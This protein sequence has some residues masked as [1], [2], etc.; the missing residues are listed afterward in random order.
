MAV[1]AE[2]RE[3]SRL[4]IESKTAPLLKAAE[5]GNDVEFIK[6]IERFG[7]DVNA[8]DEE[9]YYTPLMIAAANSRLKVVK[10]LL[11]LEKDKFVLKQVDAIGWNALIWACWGV[12]A[13]RGWT[14]ES[15]DVI[16]S[17]CDAYREKPDYKD[18]PEDLF[19]FHKTHAGYTPLMMFV[20]NAGKKIAP[21]DSGS[22]ETRTPLT[23]I[24]ETLGLLLPSEKD[25]ERPLAAKLVYLERNQFGESAIQLCRG[26]YGK[27]LKQKLI[28]E[29]KEPPE[30]TGEAAQQEQEKPEEATG[31][32][33]AWCTMRA[34]KGP[35]S[36]T[37][38]P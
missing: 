14:D 24:E 16:K 8:R 2:K 26:K 13:G 5:D 31:G 15:Q 19:L 27:R 20:E 22:K 21:K 38:Q 29:V 4:Q 6:L 32:I 34:S 7:Y 10:Y 25:R 28:K 30:K 23:M 33:F 17:I 1:D 37:A 18:K 35:S 9:R 11:R 36:D 3:K 12:G